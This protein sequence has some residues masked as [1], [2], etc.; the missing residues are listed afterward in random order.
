MRSIRSSEH[1]SRSLRYW[2]RQNVIDAAPLWSEFY[3]SLL[4]NVRA[5]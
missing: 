1:G 2:I 3:R 4:S 5:H